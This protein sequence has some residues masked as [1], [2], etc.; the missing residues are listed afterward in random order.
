MTKPKSLKFVDTR[1]LVLALMSKTV[2]ARS[3]KVRVK[4]SLF[5]APVMDLL[6]EEI[7]FDVLLRIPIF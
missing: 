1:H 6:P 5:V 4:L 7:P 3:V 2:V